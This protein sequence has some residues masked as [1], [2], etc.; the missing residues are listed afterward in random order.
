MCCAVCA[1]G[2]ASND[3]HSTSILTDGGDP[4][5]GGIPNGACGLC[6]GTHGKR[7]T[8]QHKDQ[9]EC[10]LDYVHQMRRE[11]VFGVLV[12]YDIV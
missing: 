5:A 10:S 3:A 12:F 7:C 9:G 6:E 2:G 4:T 11:C 8:G 1:V